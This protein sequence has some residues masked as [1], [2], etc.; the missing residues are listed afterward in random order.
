MPV[1]G[2]ESIMDNNTQEIERLGIYECA[3]IFTKLGFMFREQTIGDYG[4][5]AIIETKN[6]DY[7]SGKMIAVQI[8]SGDSYFSEL[9][10]NYVV[11]RGNIKHY[12]YWINHSL[13]VI[14]VLY[15]PSS[16]KCIWESINNETANRCQ[17]GWKIKIPCQQILENSKE[18]LQNLANKQSEYERR[19]TSLVI[20]KEWMLETK[21]RG[22]IILEVQEWINKTS[23]RGTFILKSGDGEGNEKIFFNQN[24]WGFGTKSYELVIQELFPWA[25]IRIDE[26]FYEENMDEDCY[27]RRNITDRELASILGVKGNDLLKYSDIPHKL[28]PYRNGAGEVDFYRLKLTLNQVGRSFLEMDHF[29]ETGKC[30]FIDNIVV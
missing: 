17:S 16:G 5:D 19:W 27:Q 24:L 9:N 6:D 15:S 26:E 1:V 2:K 21:E 4:I 25:D 10:D 29:L 13:P 18:K 28:Y 23:G 14:I 8:K 7:L 30:Y 12:N 11:F 22:A 3:S 20:A